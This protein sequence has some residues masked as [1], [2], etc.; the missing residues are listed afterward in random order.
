M[1]ILRKRLE[2]SLRGGCALPFGD[3]AQYLKVGFALASLA[4][5]DE[6]RGDVLG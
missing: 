3:G 2:F 5:T 6:V 1:T 4:M